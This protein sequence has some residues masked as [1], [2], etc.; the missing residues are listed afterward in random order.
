MTKTLSIKGLTVRFRGIVAVN[1]LDMEIEGGSFHSLIGPNGAGK[2]TVINAITR[3]VPATGTAL[4]DGKTDLLKLPAHRIS[5]TG[6]ARTFQN[7]ELFKTMSV[8]A[9]LLVGAHHTIKYGFA[10]EIFRTQRFKTEQLE[11]T[12]RVI[13]VADF[14]YIK[15][16]MNSTVSSLPYGIQKMVEIGRALMSKPSLILLDEPF[17]GLN[18][19]ET[20]RLKEELLRVKDAYG[21]TVLM[22]EHD[23][24]TVMRLSDRITVINFGEKIAEGNPRDIKQNRRVVEA[25]LGDRAIT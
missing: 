22:I 2:T 21:L 25:Y 6:M 7:L 19:S 1:N 23:M 4:F 5:D 14:L 16:Y 17:A 13:E 15:E 20:E 18:D 12:E 24:G 8:A 10:D 9:N 11:L 3:V